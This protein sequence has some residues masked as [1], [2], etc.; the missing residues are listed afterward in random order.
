MAACTQRGHTKAPVGG[1]LRAQKPTWSCTPLPAPSWTRCWTQRSSL[2]IV[3][4]SKGCRWEAWLSVLHATR[5]DCSH[6]PHSQPHPCRTRPAGAVCQGRS[7][8]LALAHPLAAAAP[9]GVI[10]AWC[11]WCAQCTGQWAQKLEDGLVRV[12][13]GLVV[14]AL[15]ACVH[16]HASTNVCALRQARTGRSH[17]AGCQPGSHAGSRCDVLG[18][19]AWR[20]AAV[21]VHAGHLSAGLGRAR[22]FAPDESG[23]RPEAAQG[24]GAVGDTRG[25]PSRLCAKQRWGVAM[26]ASSPC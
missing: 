14:R 21:V 2:R 5:S 11:A 17:A 20:G 7:G 13:S 18:F 26:Q 12:G 19:A 1:R 8:S 15:T 24:G 6:R 10:P 23:G 25:V 16:A 3:S 9:A 4:Q 22:R